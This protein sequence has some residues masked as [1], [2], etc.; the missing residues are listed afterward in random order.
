MNIVDRYTYRVTWSDD[1]E[2]FVGLCAEFPSLSHLDKVRG[3]A[4][5]GIIELVRG[6]VEDMKESGEAIPQ[7]LQ[8][9]K[10][11]GELRLRIPPPM[12]A[13]L[14]LRAAEEKTSINR[15][16]IESLS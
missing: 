2:E 10:Y 4:L 15:L 1:D 12:H 16:I 7:P 11:S 3:K 14:A 13:R 9:R 6:V 5:E 8:D